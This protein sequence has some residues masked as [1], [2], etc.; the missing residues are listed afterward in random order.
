M[1]QH[2][3]DIADRLVYFF[4][5]S[6]TIPERKRRLFLTM[7]ALG[8]F[9]LIIDTALTPI[10]MLDWYNALGNVLM[11]GFLGALSWFLWRRRERQELILFA[12][13]FGS[14]LYL[15]IIMIYNT[16]R[17]PPPQPNDTL[18][19]SVSPW[20]IWFIL[21]EMLCFLT[22]R[23]TT[24]LR[25]ALLITILFV[26]TLAFSIYKISPLPPLALHDL[27]L[28]LTANAFVILMAFPLAQT[29][30][31]NAQT[32]FLAGLA[33]RSHGYTALLG[34]IER[35]QRYNATFAVILFD[36]DHF[37]KINDTCGHP[38][39]DAVLRELAAFV[40]EHIR[41]TDLLTRWG[42]EE[43]LL[44]MTHTDLASARLKAD[45][46]RQQ[47]KNRPFH[48]NIN[49]TASFGITSHYPYDSANS[50][51]E[52]VDDALYRAKRNG[53]NCVEVE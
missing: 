28:L 20:L 35:A 26:I 16:Q 50:I 53:R 34:E 41:R 30:E 6:D 39:G 15:V 37:K 33:N 19:R 3:S 7:L 51:L 36:I 27:A 11:I 22:F 8:I 47:I 42:G 4:G 49:L 31:H 46:L 43:F 21:L 24:A 14:A 25:M 2:G 1:L 32:D 13:F 5:L 18:L 23:A 52:R 40:N 12:L 9:L 10:L 45:H 48:K 29:Q 38:C 44:L 17:L